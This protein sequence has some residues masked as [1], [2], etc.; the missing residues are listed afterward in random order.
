MEASSHDP[1]RAAM[2]N[3][4]DAHA[5]ALAAEQHARC[6]SFVFRVVWRFVQSHAPSI[7]HT[8][9]QLCEKNH[10]EVHPWIAETGESSSYV[11]D[12]AAV[13]AH[14]AERTGQ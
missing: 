8:V 6:A 5:D 10:A 12:G 3:A 4:Y 1:S 14:T 11:V 2:K 9:Q 7:Q 13:A